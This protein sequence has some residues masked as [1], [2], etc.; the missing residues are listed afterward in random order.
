MVS[1]LISF[2]HD[3]LSL[4]MTMKKLSFGKKAGIVASVNV[5]CSFQTTTTTTIHLTIVTGHSVLGK[6]FLS[7]EYFPSTIQKLP[8][9]LLFILTLGIK[10]M[11]QYSKRILD[12][13]RKDVR[14]KFL[15]VVSNSSFPRYKKNIFSMII[16][17]TNKCTQMQVRTRIFSTEFNIFEQ[18]LDT[19]FAQIMFFGPF[20]H[21]SFIQKGDNELI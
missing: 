16:Y 15:F 6:K 9:E 17:S 7:V 5:C 14:M 12:L 3:V 13:G 2:G 18:Y 11:N 8:T 19:L 10:K 21:F 20:L 4:K 1:N